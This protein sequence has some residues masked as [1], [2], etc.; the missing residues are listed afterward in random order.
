MIVPRGSPYYTKAELSVFLVGFVAAIIGA[1]GGS[2]C[3]RSTRGVDAPELGPVHP[4]SS[5]E[6]IDRFV[7]SILDKPHRGKKTITFG[8]NV[9]AG[10]SV[11]LLTDVTSRTAAEIERIASKAESENQSLRVVLVF[12]PFETRI[13]GVARY[14]RQ[15]RFIDRTDHDSAT[16][17]RWYN[18]EI[19]IVRA[20]IS[21]RGVP[22]A[23]VSGA[24]PPSTIVQSLVDAG[25]F[26]K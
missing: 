2:I 25:V 6:E 14:A 11:F 19:E 22:V 7:R 1:R 3:I 9:A 26:E 13:T 18:R 23:I 12:D 10:T 21:G 24:M 8:E 17:H 4:N 15:T 16:I 5:M 20:R